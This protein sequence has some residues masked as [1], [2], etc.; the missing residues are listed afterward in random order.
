MIALGALF[1]PE[2]WPDPATGF[3]DPSPQTVVG[4]TLIVL[5]AALQECSP[6]GV[7]PI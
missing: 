3:L 6:H 7:A 2:L 4:Q 1:N 5:P